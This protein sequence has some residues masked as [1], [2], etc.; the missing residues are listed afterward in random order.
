MYPLTLIRISRN[1]IVEF[2][3]KNND[4]L[5]GLLHRCD[6]AMNLHL[7]NV[8]IEKV[9]GKSVFINECYLKGTSIKL[10][11]LESKL[12]LEQKEEERDE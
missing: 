10:A 9:N 8:T 11:R 3:L 6:M 12:L 5:R 2:E 4:Q 7:R 1:K